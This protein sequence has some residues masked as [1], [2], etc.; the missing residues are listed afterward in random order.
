MTDRRVPQYDQFVNEEER[1]WT[2]HSPPNSTTTITTTNITSNTTTNTTVW[3]HQPY[4]ESLAAA[5]YV[6]NSSTSSLAA[7]PQLHPMAPYP[8]MSPINEHQTMGF[9]MPGSNS[10][11]ASPIMPPMPS[12]MVNSQHTTPVSSNYPAL[13]VSPSVHSHLSSSYSQPGTNWQMPNANA[14][15]SMALPPVNES[16]S[17]HP[18]ESSIMIE[19]NTS[20]AIHPIGMPH[21]PAHSATHSAA[22]HSPFLSHMQP[23]HT[24]TTIT[25]APPASPLPPPVVASATVSP[26]QVAPQAQQDFEA[27]AHFFKRNA[28]PLPLPQLDAYLNLPPPPAS[29]PP[30]SEEEKETEKKLKNQVNDALFPPFSHLPK[31]NTVEDLKRK[32]TQGANP[33]QSAI[34]GAIAEN[35]QRLLQGTLTFIRLEI[36]R[37][38]VQFLG[39]YLAILV[40]N[41]GEN[42][43]VVFRNITNFLSLRF[44]EVFRKG[45]IF[46]LVFSVI[47]LI[48][49][50]IFTILRQK[51]P[52]A[53][54]QGL[55]VDTW[56][57]RT[58]KIRRRNMIMLFILTTLYLPLLS[59]AFGAIVWTDD[60]WP[61]ANPYKLTDNPNFDMMPHFCYTTTMKVGEFNSAYLIVPL[62]AIIVI[63]LGGYFPYALFKLIRRNQPKVDRYDENGD[64]IQDYRQEYQRRLEQDL[65]PYNFL[66]SGYDESWSW[67]KVFIMMAKLL[68]V[69]VAVIVSKDNCLFRSQPRVH[70]ELSRQILLIILN[71][72][73]LATHLRTQAFLLPAQ[74]HSETSSRL[75][76]V[77]I[78]VIGVFVVLK[79]G[80][81]T[82]LNALLLT[83]G[84]VAT[85][86]VLYFVLQNLDI[87]KRFV[88]KVTH[89][90][91][92]DPLLLDPNLNVDKQILNRVWQ[93]SW[94]ALF[95]ITKQ[96]RLPV[97]K[98][99]PFFES[100]NMSPYLL[101]FNGTVA[102]RHMENLKIARHIGL[103]EFKEALE[104]PSERM[105][106]LRRIVMEELSGT[107]I[108]HKPNFQSKLKSFFGRSF[109][110][111]FPFCLVVIYDEDPQ[112][113]AQLTTEE[114]LEE[115][116]ATNRRP[117]IIE[118]RTNRMKLRA[119]D[120]CTVIVPNSLFG[121]TIKQ[122]STG[123][124]TITRTRSA[125]WGKHDVGSGFKVSI[126]VQ[127]TGEHNN[128][129]KTRDNHL[130]GKH[131][132]PIM[133]IGAEKRILD[134]HDLG[135]Q[136]DFRLTTRLRD[137]F[138]VNNTAID[139][140]LPD[141]ERT[142]KDYR[143]YYLDMAKAKD[144]T[145][146]YAFFV[147]VYC[148]SEISE[149]RLKELLANE[150]KE[151]CL[152]A[153]LRHVYRSEVHL[154]WY[155][156]WDDLYRRNWQ[157]IP[158]FRKRAVDFSPHS[159]DSICYRPMSRTELEKFIAS[160]ERGGYRHGKGIA[161]FLHAGIINRLYARLDAIVA[162]DS[163]VNTSAVMTEDVTRNDDRCR[164]TQA[165]YQQTSTHIRMPNA[166]SY[167][168]K[169]AMTVTDDVT[170]ARP[171]TFDANHPNEL[172]N[173]DIRFPEPD[174]DGNMYW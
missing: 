69:L 95:L 34:M 170:L 131:K 99:L 19:T 16:N 137:F 8:S 25:T 139:I 84:I 135:I 39:V 1:P 154:W 125:F 35:S 28:Q 159:P 117:E 26:T 38:F 63:V 140:G 106:E 31:G 54:Q 13:P 120:G 122:H 134:Q 98:P 11:N 77:T 161:N 145:L 49:L 157:V 18:S 58:A 12:S 52:N 102:E 47:C 173:E 138:E 14:S 71:M 44:S 105:L 167:Y 160:N 174:H 118:A 22:P 89:E 5:P 168:L 59:M 90:V 17:W 67:Y 56:A 103:R 62:A 97:G 111:P 61:V 158:Q 123:K 148:N 64:P 42:F 156:F 83:V 57:K 169:A 172:K 20:P 79:M 23:N 115:Y 7:S 88:R 116:V 66:Y 113:S 24:T 91:E 87:F 30:A 164:A 3:P 43:M 147:D 143:D 27:F 21:S 130:F 51:D 101:K 128:D 85:I 45:A 112:V 150:E 162:A 2:S 10:G 72:I 80:S 75:A 41:L 6:N 107:D 142:L 92:L 29:P 153:R 33:F 60:F 68:A 46:L 36:V 136:H 65:S 50:T 81:V 149:E 109:V 166:G 121:P 86:I 76:Q 163:D 96:F 15:T 74:N 93:E 53:D 55:E 48:A 141:V 110:L 40:P 151:S 129:K 127:S 78:G 70:V 124:L 114:E 108:Y 94:S 32:G 171:P 132:S 100:R 144:N 37:D 152:Y 82:V 133:S 4:H 165:P 126:T 9:V 119:L 155:I 146:S 73:L 104:H